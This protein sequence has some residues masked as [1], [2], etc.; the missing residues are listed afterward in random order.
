V[1]Q[2]DKEVIEME[3]I[4][5]RNIEIAYDELGH[6]LPIVLLHGFPLN[7]SMWQKQAE[8]LSSKYRVILPDLRGHGETSIGE[9]PIKID[10]MARDV[11]AILDQLNIDRVTIGGLSMGG[12][13]A[14]AFYRQ[15]PLRVR[16]LILADTRPQADSEEGRKNREQ[17]ADRVM[18]EGMTALAEAQIPKL[19]AASSLKDKPEIVEQVRS[20]IL[21]TKPKA[22]AATLKGLAI[23]QDH[24][25][26]L[27]NILPPTLI[28]VGEED[29]ITPVA[30]AE[31]MHKEIRGS[32]L[33]VIK[34]AGHVSNLEQPAD[35]NQA[36]LNFLTSL[37]P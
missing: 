4:R 35:F 10:E 31:L 37:E 12:Y 11:A 13:V 15:F 8:A 3:I 33:E 14:L 32:H 20:M 26:F 27:A 1:Y 5:V 36:L 6:G 34:R 30:D 2:E 21:S 28:I 16:A 25:S 17:M 22:A 9:G 23:R 24:T 18:K 29:A 7:R 19:F